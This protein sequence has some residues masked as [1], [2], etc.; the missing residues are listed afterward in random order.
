MGIDTDI[1]IDIDIDIDTDIDIDIDMHWSR[2]LFIHEI[3]NMLRWLALLQL[4]RRILIVE[5]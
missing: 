3:K 1:G 5:A 2:S 4:F